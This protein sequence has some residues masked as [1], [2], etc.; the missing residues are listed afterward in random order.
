MRAYEDKNG[1]GKWTTGDWT[2]KR[3]PEPVYYFPARLTLRANWD[4]EE[5]FTYEEKPVL[6]SKPY[7]IIEDGAKKLNNKKKK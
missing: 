6:E 2:A 7:E 4:F 1:D 5:H 3:Q